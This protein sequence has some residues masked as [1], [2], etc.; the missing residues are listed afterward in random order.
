MNQ[1]EQEKGSFVVTINREV[2]SGGRTIGEM[3]AK[4]LDV[5]YYYKAVA[6]T[7][8]NHFHLSLEEIE[9]LKLKHSW[10]QEA[11]HRLLQRCSEWKQVEESSTI[12]IPENIFKV[13]TAALRELAQKGSCVI[14]GRIT[15]HVF[16]TDSNAIKVFVTS[17]VENRVK[18]IMQKQGLS[19]REAQELLYK[20]DA[21]RE[22]YTKRFT[23]MSRYDT[24]NYD[25]VLDV[26]NLTD[27]EAAEVIWE[28]VNKK[29]LEK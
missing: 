27:E 21:G 4:R 19:L 10:W 9:R 2:G 12:P 20:L 13:E 22:S 29:R 24:R 5:P 26:T 16:R 7:V 8:A 15:H 6:E 11:A 1:E 3:V 23:G 14:A 25:L 18:R 17:R 28:Y